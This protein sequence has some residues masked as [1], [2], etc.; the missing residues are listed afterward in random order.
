M[1]SVRLT[2]SVLF[3]PTLILVST[4]SCA[5]RLSDLL[6]GSLG[7]QTLNVEQEAEPL[8]IPNGMYEFKSTGDRNAGWLDPDA[9]LARLLEANGNGFAAIGVTAEDDHEY[10]CFCDNV[11][12]AGWLYV[13]AEDKVY[14]KTPASDPINGLG[15][16]AEGD[17]TLSFATSF[18]GANDPLSFTVSLSATLTPD[19]EG[20]T[21]SVQLVAQ[22]VATLAEEIPASGDGRWPIV[23]AG[24]TATYIAEWTKTLS[25]SQAPATL[26]RDAAWELEPAEM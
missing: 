6:F 4:A 19:D 23:P 2:A 1:R 16:T 15:V 24:A 14:V 22:A 7:V 12:A 5:P 26:Y 9:P 8:A 17:G 20:E 25:P 21:W 3:V 18:G 10:L 11:I 13:A